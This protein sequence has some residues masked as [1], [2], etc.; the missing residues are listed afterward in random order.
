MDG[1]E[2]LEKLGDG[3]YSVV[4]KVRRKEDSN[5]Y[6]LKKVRLQNLS[7]KEKEN[8]LNEVRI[9]ASVKSTFVI[10]YKEAF[11]DEKDQSLCIVM[12][13]AD[14]GD[15]YQKI[16]QFKKIGCLIE[17]VD[18]WRI[19]I[20]MVKGLKALH[21][22]KILHRDL[23]SANIFLFSDGSAKIGD[24]NVSKVA[25][26]GLGYTQTGTPYYASP[27]VWRDEPYDIKSDIWSLACVTYEMLALHPPFRAENMEALYN[28]VVK[29]QY[30]KISERY[31][32]DISEIIKLLLKVKSKERP[33]CGQILK[34]PLVKKRIEFF[35][36]EAGNENI[37][38]DDMEEGVLLRTIRIPK[39]I[40]FLSD[41]L[42]EANYEN[43]YQKVKN[44]KDGSVEKNND[45]INNINNKGNTFP[46]SCLPDIN[47]KFKKKKQNENNN[48]TI[49][50]EEEKVHR[51]TD[52]NINNLNKNIKNN[53]QN[54]IL[55]EKKSDGMGLLKKAKL[56]KINDIHNKNSP[57]HKSVTEMNPL[58]NLSKEKSSLSKNSSS[59]KNKINLNIKTIQEK[60]I[61]NQYN[62]EEKTKEDN[63]NL[64]TH[65]RFQSRKNNKRLKELQKYFNDL[66][67]NEAY[68]LY[69]PQLNMV[70]PNN[71]N[72]NSNFQNSN[73]YNSNI[74]YNNKKSKGN[75]YGQVL[76]N[77]Y[78]NYRINRNN[79]NSL[80]H[81][82]NSKY[83]L[84]P[85]P[86]PNRKL[87]LLLNKKF[88]IKL[89]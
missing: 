41:K 47:L 44:K 21:D 61:D 69:I 79:S 50:N 8:S 80:N 48:N 77:L 76:P 89:I 81:Y 30:G 63:L 14:K 60:T 22:L 84:I 43:P 15:L 23:K 51:E 36:A 74:K 70:S 52:I 65:K 1:F 13:Y 6:A 58:V 45:K 75:R 68:K 39:N 2:I 27:E 46:N 59:S 5:I 28:K 4:Y 3:A 37:D 19:F 55:K 29:C 66:G 72:S 7:D 83:D 35:Q 9:L 85:K 78:Q 11:I 88:G 49:N 62:N 24:L 38:I 42:P 20:Q 16:C 86:L 18:V 33:T 87:N 31:S 67:I 71:N 82:D 73:N 64:P 10:A 34:H 25:H 26:K 54:K 17:E 12:E 56:I 32:S 53:L 40:L 57:K